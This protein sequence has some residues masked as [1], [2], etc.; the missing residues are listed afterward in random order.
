M[1]SIYA[2]FD[3][4]RDKMLTAVELRPFFNELMIQRRDLCLS[5]F[6]YDG[7]F[8]SIDKDRDGKLD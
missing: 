8:N 3:K 7:W 1:T 4:N 2:R 5:K 6:N